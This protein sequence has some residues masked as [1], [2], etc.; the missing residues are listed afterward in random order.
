MK[1]V[2]SV[3]FT[4]LILMSC[5]AAHNTKVKEKIAKEYGNGDNKKKVVVKTTSAIKKENTPIAETKPAKTVKPLLEKDD[6]ETLIATSKV[7][8]S[9]NTVEDYINLY[10]GAAMQSM[11]T[12]GIPASIKLAQGILES[13]SGNGTLCRTANNHFGI[14]CKEEW[15]GET[16]SHTDDAPNECFRKYTTAIESYNDHSE[17]LANRV[18][19]KNLFTL[20]KKD[21]TAWAKG[22]KKAGYATDPRYP[23]K[24]ISIIERYKLYEYDQKVL[25][26]DYQFVAN[27]TEEVVA[28]NYGAQ[29]QTYTVQAGDTLYGICQK[30]NSSVDYIKQLNQLNTNTLSVGQI[31]K[32]Q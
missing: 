3:L 5:N 25:G 8:V 6:S 15:T 4:G 31:I 11:R 26:S 21:Y 23:Q 32:I 2:L 27:K 10:S 18:Y 9:K 20:D 24:L 12:Y 17:F 28:T 14:K 16:V 7:N 29:A 1:K 19:Y 13:G 22:L 30:F